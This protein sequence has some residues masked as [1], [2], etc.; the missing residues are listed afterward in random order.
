MYSIDKSN[1]K[2]YLVQF[3][4]Q[5]FESKSLF[6]SGT[7][8]L[9]K[10][11][12]K[13]IIYIGMGGSAIAGDIIHDSFFDQLSIPFQV[14]RGYN[15]PACCT[16]T[17]LVIT[18]S[19]SGNTEET[20]AALGQASLRESQILAITSGGELLKKAIEKKWSYIKI[21]DGFPPRQA[22]G[23]S[24]FPILYLL[25]NLKFIKISENEIKSIINL[26]KS[27]V[28]RNDVQKSSA[29]ILMIDLATKIN[30]NIPI[31][32]ATAPYLCAVAT[33]W[34]NQ[35]QENSKTQ[36]FSNVI[37]EMNHNEIVG[38]EMNLTDICNFLVIFLESQNVHPRIAM[39]INLT[40]KI[41]RDKG[42]E[43]VEIY[44]EGSTLLEQTV[45][46]IAKGDWVSYYLALINKKDPMAIL[47]ID[48]LKA[49][50]KKH[51]SS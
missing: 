28:E 35:F 36:A 24:F 20:L 39:R 11:L 19:Y 21:P 37:P 15:I 1:F 38:W 33:R 5:I 6:S 4:N 10:K 9:N 32:Y 34:K 50:M 25:N 41:I 14:I 45:S 3:P 51:T 42:I 2:E 16:K 49:E 12:I 40:K 17:S 23:Y 47:N 48:Y 13:N 29:K 43:L 46:F 30:K 44:P 22:F 26:T 27:I 8:N 7:I 18:S 31:I